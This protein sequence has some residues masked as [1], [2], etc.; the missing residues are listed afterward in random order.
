MPASIGRLGLSYRQRPEYHWGSNWSSC[1]MPRKLRQS[2]QIRSWYN[3]IME[4]DFDLV[5]D[6]DANTLIVIES[7]LRLI[8]GNPPRLEK[9]ETV[10]TPIPTEAQWK[11]WVANRPRYSGF[12]CGVTFGTSDYL[13]E[14]RSRPAS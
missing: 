5:F 10:I 8:P 4:T 9:I 11:L 12:K 1:S 14:N 2:R 13:N 7:K 3:P 6:H